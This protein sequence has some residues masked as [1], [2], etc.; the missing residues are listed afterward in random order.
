MRAGWEAASRG[1][2]TATTARVRKRAKGNG[3]N[4]A[5]RSARSFALL[6]KRSIECPEEATNG[7]RPRP[8]GRCRFKCLWD[9]FKAEG[10]K[11]P[12]DFAHSSRDFWLLHLMIGKQHLFKINERCRL[13]AVESGSHSPDVPCGT[14]ML[15][16]T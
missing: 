12:N 1:P 9:P 7:P 14:R 3:D 13:S 8:R 16:A 6:P 10:K 5:R 15:H 4:A 2:S 11:R